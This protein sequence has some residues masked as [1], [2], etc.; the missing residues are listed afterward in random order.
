MLQ[1]EG[2]KPAPIPQC[3]HVPAETQSLG[4]F[5]TNSNITKVQGGHDVAMMW[6][7]CGHVGCGCYTG[8]IWV[9]HG[10]GANSRGSL[11]HP[12]GSA[13]CY[14]TLT[15]TASAKNPLVCP[16]K[17]WSLKPSVEESSFGPPRDKAKAMQGCW[18]CGHGGW[19]CSKCET[20]L[21]QQ[22]IKCHSHSVIGL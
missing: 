21:I 6:P 4:P 9:Q 3:Q 7:W 11:T 16:W 10:A 2:P 18:Q 1:I 14:Q 12:W 17:L 13:G 19:G 5:S 20:A 8:F 15:C 22:I